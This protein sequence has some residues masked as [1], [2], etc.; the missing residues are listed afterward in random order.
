[1]TYG[2][3]RLAAALLFLLPVRAA[4]AAEPA[5]I[6]RNGRLRVLVFPE[7]DRPQFFSVR[8]DT[9]PGFE[10]EILDGFAR[11]NGL[12]LEIVA[13][14]RWDALIPFLTEDKGDVIAGH[15]TDIPSRRT[16][17]GFT[18]GVLPT[19]SVVITRKP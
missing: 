1:M 6:V 14:P 17:V 8:A 13:V 18:A 5:P 16:R 2:L 4:A 19:R 10:R 3:R 11:A 12:T 9:A 7:E 15:F